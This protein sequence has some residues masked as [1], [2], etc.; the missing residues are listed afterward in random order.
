MKKYASTKPLAIVFGG[1]RVPASDPL[2]AEAVQLGTRL[3]GEGWAVGSGGYSGVMAGVS[4]GASRAGGAVI[5][6]TCDIFVG[7]HQPNRWLTEERRTVTLP[8][9]IARMIQ[10]G[11]AFIA[12]KGGIG[13]LAEV[14]LLWNML[15]LSTNGVKP[16]VLVGEPWPPFLQ[17]LR[18][19]S[20]MGRSAFRLVQTAAT[21]SEAVA[22]LTLPPRGS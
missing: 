1:A 2:Y 6:Y 17:W 4:E 15:L 5:G 9:R 11:D 14:T 3:V 8:E 12:M 18:E 19:R 13:T 16:F 22:F 7:N 20:Q 21:P 10:E